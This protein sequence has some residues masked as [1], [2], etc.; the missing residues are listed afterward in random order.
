MEI[1]IPSG[2]LG[3]EYLIVIDICTVVE[4]VFDGLLTSVIR[5]CISVVEVLGPLNEGIVEL[6]TRSGL[7]SV[8][9]NY[10][11]AKPNIIYCIVTVVGYPTSVS[12]VED[13]D[14]IFISC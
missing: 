1:Y 10:L 5:S 6:E 13:V 2:N 8:G 3:G 4:E 9:L 7:R 12:F 11:F 14:I